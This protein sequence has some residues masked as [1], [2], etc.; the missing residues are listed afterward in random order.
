MINISQIKPKK[1]DN[2]RLI[3]NDSDGKVVFLNPS[4]PSWV[5]LMPSLAILLTLCDGHHTV[6]ELDKVF[7]TPGSQD[8][9]STWITD[10]LE[11]FSH[12]EMLESTD[13]DNSQAYLPP[14]ET[15]ALYLTKA[16]NLSCRFCFYSAGNPFENELT[17][18]EIYRLLDD[19][20]TLNVKTVFCLG[21]E[22]LLRIDLFEICRYV[23]ANGIQMILITNG[24]LITRSSA[25]KI[26]EAFSDVQVSIDGLDEV[27]QYVRGKGSFAKAIRGVRYLLEQGVPVTVASTLSRRNIRGL[28]SFL[29]QL[30]AM[31]VHKFHT[32]NM[33]T[34]GRAHAC[35][36]EQ[37]SHHEYMHE[38][39]LIFQ[40]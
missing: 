1:I 24:T 22:P 2:L 29:D 26:K 16:C 20:K 19:L 17:T 13:K 35:S 23:K 12:L 27:N 4:G 37:L 39:L 7:Q 34:F 21:G 28:D 31:G 5:A 6:E 36:A 32:T 30:S 40:K 8:T 3:G 11:Y 33:Q 38:M 25:K 15:V 18:A 10:A 9:P 14:L